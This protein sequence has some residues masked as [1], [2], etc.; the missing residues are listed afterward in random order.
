MSKVVRFPLQKKRHDQ[1]VGVKEM[2]C[3]GDAPDAMVW[4]MCRN[5]KRDQEYCNECPR[6]EEDKDYGKVQR[7]CFGMAQEACRYGLAWAERIQQ[8][9]KHEDE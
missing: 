6:W 4:D 8:N 3:Q 1:V 2:Y 9:I 5:T 7:G